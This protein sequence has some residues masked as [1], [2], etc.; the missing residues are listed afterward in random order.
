[1]PLSRLEL[2][3][4]HG[5]QT[6][7]RVRF[8]LYPA[9]SATDAYAIQD[10]GLQFTEGK[11]FAS[12]NIIYGHEAVLRGSASRDADT[13]LG[14][15][16]GLFILSLPPNLHLGYGIF[17]SAYIDRKQ[18]QVSGSPIKYAAARDQLSL[19]VSPEA[20]AERVHIEAEVA[21]GYGLDQ[22]PVYML[23]SKYIV[24][25]FLFSDGFD[26][27]IR[28]LGVKIGGFEG[29]DYDVLERSF[30]DVM[31]ASANSNP[32][33]AE[34]ALRDLVTGTVESMI[35]ARLRMMR[36]HNLVLLGYKFYEGDRQIQ[37]PGV[38]NMADQRRKMDDVGRLLA[39]SMLFNAELEWLKLFVAKELEIMRIELEGSELAN[40]PD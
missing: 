21:N 26:Q 39:S 18:K 36:W 33:V 19:Y 35:I 17:T 5:D 28:Q 7:S 22:R 11:P 24:G 20:E 40:L 4:Q 9:R 8:F 38:T 3:A 14:E 27:L 25:K 23:E 31:R 15:E 12:T 13:M 2:V 30:L 6:L 32:G 10:T 16:G 34:A 37:I 29:L 1:M